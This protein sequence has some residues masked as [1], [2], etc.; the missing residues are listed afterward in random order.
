MTFSRGMLVAASVLVLFN[1][2]SSLARRPRIRKVCNG[3]TFVC[4]HG[5][6][7]KTIAKAVSR[8]RDGDWILVWP[9]VYHE[10]ATDS[11]GVYI[12]TP[13]IH[14]RGLDRN[15]VIVDGSNGTAAQPCPADAASQDLTA[16]NGIE[17]FKA[18]GVSIENL[19]VC[20]YL[21]NGGEGNEIW[22]NGG[23]G[24]GQIGMGAY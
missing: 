9:G 20:N 1:P 12:T 13:N 7:Y 11:A 19:T 15:L 17:V 5:G 16:R 24:S 2:R 18:D 10:K 4:P 21:A 8:A 3:S 22:W 6:H 23:D 14:L